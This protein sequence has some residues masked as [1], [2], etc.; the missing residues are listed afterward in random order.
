MWSSTGRCIPLF[1]Y[2]SKLYGN[3]TYYD[4]QFKILRECIV[5]IIGTDVNCVFEVIVS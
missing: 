3:K 2:L 5:L 1:V 4:E